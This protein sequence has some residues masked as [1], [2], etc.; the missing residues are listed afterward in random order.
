ADLNPELTG[1]LLTE[2]SERIVKK[3]IREFLNN[4]TQHVRTMPDNAQD[5]AVM[6]CYREC[7]SNL[8]KFNGIGEQKAV[9]FINNIERIGKMI[10]ANN[11]IL[12]CMCTAKLD[13]E[14]KPW[15]ENNMALTQWKNLK[16]AFLERFTT[17]DASSRIFE[18]LKECK[19]KPDEIVT[20]YYDAIIKL[21]HEYDTNM[22]EKM[23][24]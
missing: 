4:I 6:I 20:S 21:C 16:S 9:Q 3:H 23:M 2:T 11:N 8:E 24:I 5:P 7:L 15:Y 17:A 13:G 12:C 18:Q 19:Q 1:D 22:S 10:D 14:A